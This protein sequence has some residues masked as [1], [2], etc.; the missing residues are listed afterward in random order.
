[1]KSNKLTYLTL[2]DILI[3]TLLLFGEAT[4]QS[5]MLFLNSSGVG[6]PDLTTTTGEQNIQMF[7]IQGLTLLV[8]FLYLYFRKFDFSQWK[9]KISLRGTL[10]GFGLFIFL[11]LSMELLSIIGDASYRE[12]FLTASFNPISG[13]WIAASRFTLPM[14]AYAILNGIY[15]EIYFIGM[16]TAV[17]EKYRHLVFGF[18]LFVRIA[19]HT[20]QG[21]LAA[22]GI[23]LILGATYYFWYRKKGQDLYPIFL[24]HAIADI[25]G[26]SV[27]S[28][29][30][31]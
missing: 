9:C 1:M 29:L 2:W 4:Y 22:F 26:L 11:S 17:K 28:Y 15:E 18:S 5:T 7:I 3:L 6:V 21:L 12:Y 8:A 19:F 31:I 27:I 25:L 20:Y 24:S 13:L 10:I 23:G 14:V 16:C 30:F